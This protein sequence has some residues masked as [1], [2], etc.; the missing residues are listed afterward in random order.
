[1]KRINYILSICLILLLIPSC[2]Y[3]N[4]YQIDGK[5]QHANGEKVYLEDIFQTPALTIDTAT[6]SGSTFHL[7]NYSD[8]GIYRLRFGDNPD[9]SLFIYL[10]KKQKLSI[11]ADFKQLYNYTISGNK[12][13]QTIAQLLNTNYQNLVQ[14]DSANNEYMR[15]GAKQKDSMLGILKNKKSAYLDYLHNFIKKEDNADVACFA[16][17]LLE[18]YKEEEIPFII[19][20][21]KNLHESAPNSRQINLW[22]AEV[23]QYEKQLLAKQEEGLPVGEIAPNIILQNPQGDTIQLKEL[24]GKYVLL[25][26]WASWCQPCRQNNPH[27][28]QIFEKYHFQGLEI[29]S[30]SLDDT[31][32]RWMNA[33]KVDKLKWQYHGC[34]YQKWNGKAVNMY[35]VS[36]IPAVFLLDK[37]GKIIAKNL[38][39]AALDAKLNE[40]F[41]TA[42]AK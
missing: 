21:V 42:S 16:L 15:A 17:Q 32:E 8:K 4:G 31:K 29:F 10:D 28:V 12:A 20:Q 27:L 37:N 11:S 6:I 1:M 13:S 38:H 36:S 25:D 41:S 35:K 18:P 9:N 26:F 30:V 5:I 24:K 23:Q 22:Y 34:D 19:E 3:F 7:K 40:L 14:I 33:I 39:G 2:K